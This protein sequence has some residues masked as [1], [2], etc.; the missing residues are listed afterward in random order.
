MPHSLPATVIA[1]MEKEESR[2]ILLVEMG[3]TGGVTLYY[4]NQNQD[5]CFPAISGGT[6]YSS[7]EMKLSNISTS[8]ENQINRL[9][10]NLDNVSLDISYWI[11]VGDF[12]NRPLVIERVYMDA[13][14]GSTY[15]NEIFRGAMETISS[16]DYQWVSIAA[17]SGR[18][19]NRKWSPRNYNKLCPHTFGDSQCN[20]D[21]KS[22]LSSLST[23]YAEGAVSSGA[24]NYIIMDT[25]S[26]STVGEYD[27]AYNYGLMQVGLNGVTYTRYCSDYESATS[28]IW[29]R[30]AIP[31]TPTASYRYHATK[32]CA[33]TWTSCRGAFPY[34]PTAQYDA[35]NLDYRNNQANY[36]GFLHITIE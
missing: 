24:T 29:W 8:S 16:I 35:G 19:L 20:A 32:G 13:L 11:T 15:Y 26:G 2:P 22:D 14:S 10:I 3:I 33:K 7:K 34:G 28:K 18:G 25:V 17:T 5:V 1:E 6:L 31:V 4:T 12:K 27:D 9:T 36:G 23:M 21:G 30:A